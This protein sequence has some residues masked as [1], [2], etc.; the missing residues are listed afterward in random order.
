[1]DFESLGGLGTGEEARGAEPLEQKAYGASPQGA[2][3]LGKDL[4]VKAPGVKIQAGITRRRNYLGG[5]PRESSPRKGPTSVSGEAPWR[6][7]R[8]LRGL[9]DLPGILNPAKA[10]P[11][12]WTST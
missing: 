4:G 7:S 10:R 5:V 2:S 6:Q 12:G 9:G 8:S 3:V 1:M 11:A